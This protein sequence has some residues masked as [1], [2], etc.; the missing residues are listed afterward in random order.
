MEKA[1]PKTEI[2]D[3][4]FFKTE[5]L[6]PGDYVEICEGYDDVDGRED[7][8]EME[9]LSGDHPSYTRVYKTIRRTC[10]EQQEIIK[11]GRDST[12]IT[13]AFQ[14]LSNVKELVLVFRQTQGDEDWEGD[15]QELN[16]MT[17]Q[18]SYEYHIQLV[19][20]A[21]KGRSAPLQGVQLTCFELPK[22]PP[23][24]SPYWNSLTILLTELLMHAPVLRLVGSD[25]VLAL[26]SRVSL[27][28]R[29]LDMCSIYTELIFIESFLQSNAKTL[30]CL[31]VHN[32]EVTERN[33]EGTIQLT[34]AHVDDMTDLKIEREKRLDKLSCLRSFREGWKLFFNH[35]GL[36]T[37]RGNLRT[38]SDGP[39]RV[40]SKQ[41]QTHVHTYS[42]F[43]APLSCHVA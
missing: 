9:Y 42:M 19:L 37:A 4:D 20:S 21:L 35:G 41:T 38:F 25:L 23:L 1:N 13:L 30:R 36:Y 24:G 10:A 14:L 22:D 40:T 32:V 26:L 11:A 12:L 34:P 28:I 18:N 27:N 5:I 15:Y 33:K 3:Y 7:W 31:S 6:T 16:D 8:D 39:S 2:R 29:E 43:F 17:E